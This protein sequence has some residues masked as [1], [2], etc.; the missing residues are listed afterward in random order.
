MKNLSDGC[1][2]R[3]YRQ[4][5]AEAL[6]SWAKS[7]DAVR[8][9]F[10]YGSYS[11]NQ[12]SPGADLDAAVLLRKNTPVDD[13]RGELQASLGSQVRQCL[14]L[15]APDRFTCFVGD[16]LLKVECALAT[17][18]EQL[19][20]LADSTDVPAPRLVLAFERD[21]AG[22]Q[23]VERAN[24]P[25]AANA[26][27][28]INQEIEKFLEAFEA[29]SRAHCRSDAYGFYFH[30]NLALGRLARLVQ[31]ARHK[32][33]RLYL[34]PQLTNTRLRLEER[35]GFIELSGSL[36]LPEANGKKR[37]LAGKF[38]EFVT[39]LSQRHAVER[40]QAELQAF[41]QALMSR[42]YFWNVRDWAN[43]LD[44]RIRSGVI[45]RAS[46]LTRWQS[47][48]ELKR[49]LDH[50]EVKQIIDLRT[51]RPSDGE[52][53]NAETIRGI[54][55]IRVPLIQD[56]T[57]NPE[58]R[59]EHYT[60]IFLKN[61]AAIADTFRHLSVARG[62]SVVHCYAGVDRTGVVMAMLGK[63]LGLPDELLV[64]DYIV[65]GVDLHRHSMSKFLDA[66]SALGGVKSFLSRVGLDD[67]T[68]G[69]LQ[70]RF[71]A[72]EDELSR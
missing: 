24:R 60:N 2:Q 61:A 17:G 14:K 42:D 3:R 1:G 26:A 53:Y 63:L 31:I 56:S 40:S 27:K 46:T 72:T 59:S 37:K 66:I 39:E 70:Q 5:V 50:H 15:F 19:A 23:L 58:D 52:P 13:F 57:M 11:I 41:L 47:E 32:P 68:V 43:Q 35:A 8:A 25:C 30:Y 69:L 33:E 9:W 55:Y 71:H 22:Q 16:G 4:Q 51:D 12:W 6:L 36:Y 44:G 10:W 64:G 62:C 65:S 28:V 54:D 7:S 48:P 34:P 29:C 49:W 21:A 18:P 20:W 45:I 38:L 67:A